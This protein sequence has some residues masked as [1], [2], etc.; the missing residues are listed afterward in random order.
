MTPVA[1]SISQ[2]RSNSCVLGH[3][4]Q[5][6]QVPNGRKFEIQMHEEEEK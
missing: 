4:I 2:I 5:S 6:L 3:F 1:N